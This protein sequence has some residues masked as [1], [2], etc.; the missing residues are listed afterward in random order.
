MESLFG[1]R[2]VDRAP[3]FELTLK[4]LAPFGDFKSGDTLHYPVATASIESWGT[5]LELGS[6]KVMAVISMAIPHWSQIP[7]VQEKLY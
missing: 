7:W 1:A 3:S 4:F 5:L 6:G 2:L